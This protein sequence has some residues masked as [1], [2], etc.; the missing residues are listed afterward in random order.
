MIPFKDVSPQIR[1]Y[2][3][4]LAS[5]INSAIAHFSTQWSD[6]QNPD[7]DAMI[8]EA[9][10]ICGLQ[11]IPERK[12]LP[13]VNFATACVPYADIP[14][15]SPTFDK[16]TVPDVTWPDGEDVTWPEQQQNKDREAA[17]KEGLAK[18]QWAEFRNELFIISINADL[19]LSVLFEDCSKTTCNMQQH[20]LIL[21]FEGVFKWLKLLKEDA[22]PLTYIEVHKVT[23][24]V[25]RGVLKI[26]TNVHQR[27]FPIRFDGIVP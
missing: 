26:H 11:A 19:W 12:A 4:D 18:E 10:G 9:L 1:G 17:I 15:P 13:P 25:S 3:I 7:C 20:A 21:T 27:T 2:I 6:L 23:Y 14:V 22:T 24:T 8:S 5:A 16:C